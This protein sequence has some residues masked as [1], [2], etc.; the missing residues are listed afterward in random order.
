ALATFQAPNVTVNTGMTFQVVVTDLLTGRSALA[1]TLVIV[2]PNVVRP[3][4]VA[5]TAATYKA[6]R[7]VLNVSATSSDVT[8]AAVMTVQAFASNG[9]ALLP[10][11]TNMLAGGVVVGGCGYTFASAKAVFPPTGTTLNKI[12]VIS[13]EGGAAVGPNGTCTLATT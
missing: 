13:S 11:N 1:T 4:S 5:I 9:T 12:T 10:P 8:C 7:G 3:D 2:S 6:N